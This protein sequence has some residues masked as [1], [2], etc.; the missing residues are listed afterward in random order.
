H[1]HGAVSHRLR[2][3]PPEME[4]AGVEERVGQCEGMFQ[5]GRQGDGAGRA[6]ERAVREAE[7]PQREG[8][9]RESRDAR[10]VAETEPPG[11]VTLRLEGGNGKLELVEA[12]VEIVLQ[13]KA[14]PQHEMS[15]YC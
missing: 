11:P 7:H 10:V 13:G 3:A 12:A 14:G 4:E 5:L 8:R 6:F 1:S 2:L 15:V 9:G